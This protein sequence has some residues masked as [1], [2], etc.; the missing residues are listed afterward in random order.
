MNL[1][2]PFLI[3]TVP[4]IIAVSVHNGRLVHITRGNWQSFVWMYLIYS[5]GIVFIVNFIMWLS[6]PQRT[7]SFSPWVAWTTSHVLSAGFVVKYS[8][9]ATAAALVLPKLWARRNRLSKFVNKRRSF[10]I[11]DDE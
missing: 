8:L 9:V 5:F 6:Y 10:M 7:I 4:G 3:L 11:P 2:V 1:F